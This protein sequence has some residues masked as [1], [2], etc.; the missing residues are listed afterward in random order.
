LANVFSHSKEVA[1]LRIENSVA[2]LRAHQ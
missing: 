1:L 2:V